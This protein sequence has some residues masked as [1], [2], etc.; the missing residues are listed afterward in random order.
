MG[1]GLIITGTKAFTETEVFRRQMVNLLQTEA[2]REE[3]V[4]LSLGL[5]H[6]ERN[7]LITYQD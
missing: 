5:K 1:K 7:G 4:N 2:F 6:L 3:W